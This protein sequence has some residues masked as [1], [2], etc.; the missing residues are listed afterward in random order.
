M[1]EARFSRKGTLGSSVNRGSPTPQPTARRA[2]LHMSPNGPKGAGKFHVRAMTA[3]KSNTPLRHTR[4][5]DRGADKSSINRPWASSGL[6]WLSGSR[7]CPQT[8]VS[9]PLDDGTPFSTRCHPCTRVAHARTPVLK[10][11]APQLPS[12][13]Y[14]VRTL[15]AMR[16]HHPGPDLPVRPHS[17]GSISSLLAC[18]TSYIS[19]SWFAS[20]SH[21]VCCWSYRTR[22]RRAEYAFPSTLA[23]GFSVNRVA[24]ESSSRFLLGQIT[25]VTER[26]ARVII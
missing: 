18:S 20:P 7:V 8:K 12:V 9:D 3:T 24:F 14:G 15:F 16:W 17:F 1:P 13:G 5:L 25:Y 23:L 11:D 4:R 10:H 6:Y 26:L 22:I 2:Y 21:K 19:R